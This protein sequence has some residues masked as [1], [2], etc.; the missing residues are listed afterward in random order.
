MFIGRYCRSPITAY[1][2][3]GKSYEWFA[4]FGRR[5]EVFHKPRLKQPQG[6]IEAVKER[7][8][9]DVLNRFVL[10]KTPTSDPERLHVHINPDR[11]HS[12]Q[13]LTA[14]KIDVQKL[15]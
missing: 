2:A 12:D 13:L 9:Q 5:L 11:F 14:K 6:T 3:A 1:D 7:V 4:P 8:Q 15:C 10:S